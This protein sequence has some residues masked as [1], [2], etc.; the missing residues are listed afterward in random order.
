MS[1]AALK[2]GF[3]TFGCRSNHADSIELQAALVEQGAVPCSSE[4]DADVYVVNSCTVT[5]E[6]DKDVLRELR[7][8]RRRSPN[9]RIIL[10]GCMASLEDG[11]ALDHSMVDAVVGAGR[12]EA[13]L[14]A[15]NGID[16]SSEQAD[17]AIVNFEELAAKRSKRPARGGA[18]W[19]S[20][21]LDGDFPA[22]LRGPGEKLG[23]Q[24]LRARY[25]LRIQ[26]GCEN[27]CTFCIIPQ[28]RGRL[29]SRP[30][31]ELINDLAQLNDLGYGEVVLTGTHIG[32]YGE[33]LGLKLSDLLREIAQVRPVQRVRLS[34]IDP[35]DVSEEL[36]AVLSSSDIFCEH[37][38]VC[39]QA[40]SD[41]ILKKMNRKYRMSEVCSLVSRIHEVWPECTLGTDVICGFPGETAESVEEQIAAFEELGFSYVHVFPYSERSETA[42]VRLPNSVLPKER[43]KRAARWRAVGARAKRRRMKSIL[44]RELEFVVEQI[45]DAAAG[46]ELSGTSREFMSAVVS[47]SPKQA[48]LIRAGQII[49]GRA[50]E[51]KQGEEQLRCEL[52]NQESSE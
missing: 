1:E 38:H 11:I 27:S 8:I 51:L 50:T 46:V 41:P 22:A 12:R 14:K 47:L 3:K 28:T 25:H 49:R 45:R 19:R 6:A 2:V 52:L 48:K 43:K 5:D 32:G 10:T 34:S 36:L 30:V 17:P 4:E 42:A 37:L 20:I 23:E 16:G 18:N 26:E 13:V 9:A 29:S 40:F 7:R 21:S 24:K 33:D 35:N 15:V 44:S 31:A 39:V